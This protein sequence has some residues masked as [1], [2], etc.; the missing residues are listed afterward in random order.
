MIWKK[1]ESEE[2]VKDSV[3]PQ[4]SQ[5]PATRVQQQPSR[6]RAL[7]GPTI[8][9]QGDLTGNEDLQIEGRLEGKID[10]HQHNL[11]V[12]KNGRVKADVFGRQIV[13][14]G[15]VNGNLYGEERIILH[16]SSKV[17]G[18]L[19]AP[20]VTLEDGSQFKGTIDMTARPESGSGPAKQELRTAPGAVPQS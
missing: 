11:T 7:I 15:E 20:R 13:V 2:P 17:N 5:L 6:E 18:N 16:Q 4:Q 1:P 10:L 19:F 12:G 14:M 3:Q 8:E 9:I